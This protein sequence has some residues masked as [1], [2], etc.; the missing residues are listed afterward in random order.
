MCVISVS[1]KGAK[2]PVD[3]L[4]KMWDSN[5]HGAGIA[6]LDGRKVRVKK[7]FMKFDE[8][9]E[10]YGEEIPKGVMHA[11]HFRLRSAGEVV[12]QLT[13]PF[14]IDDIDSQELEYEASGVLFHNGTVADWRSLFVSVLG[15]FRKKDIDKILS[16][17]HLSDS[18][19]M[20]LLVYRRG[21]RVLKFFADTSKWLVFGPEPVFYGRWERDDRKGFAFSN[22]SWRYM[23]NV[24][25]VG[26]SNAWKGSC[27]YNK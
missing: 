14:R 12:P 7:G 11:I 13:H 16:V 1:L 20:S 18:Y 10:F 24:Y 22:M 17:E 6:W 25:G 21:P 4:K 19:V 26:Y 9:V 15:L 5:L 2:F 8:L 3:E 23:V 27:G